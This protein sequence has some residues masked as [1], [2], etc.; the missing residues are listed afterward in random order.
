[1]NTCL[2]CLGSVSTAVFKQQRLCMIFRLMYI[3]QSDF[4]K[5]SYNVT[6][7]PQHVDTPSSS[8]WRLNYCKVGPL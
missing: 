5:R 1:M 2:I 8:N 3:A 6:S 4:F 7:T